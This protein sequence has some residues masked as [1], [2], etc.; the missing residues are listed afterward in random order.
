MN[1]ADSATYQIPLRLLPPHVVTHGVGILSEVH[2]Y[3]HRLLNVPHM[4]RSTRGRGVKV[5][6]LDTGVPSHNDLRIASGYSFVRKYDFDMN[7]HATHVAG[8]I[9]AIADNG[10][11][12]AGIA[13]DCSLLCCAV[14]DRTGFGTIDQIIAGIHWAMDQ[15]AQIINMSLGMPAGIP[16][17]AKLERACNEATAAGIT[18]FCATGNAGGAVGQPATYDSVISVAAVDDGAQHADFSNHGRQVDFAAGGVRVYST[19]LNNGYARLSGT[20]MATPALSGLAALIQADHYSGKGKFLTR[21]ELYAKLRK[22]AHD[23][24][25]E[26]FDELTG[27]GIP[28]FYSQD[29]DPQAPTAPDAPPTA[30]E[31]VTGPVDLSPK[32]GDIPMPPRSGAPEATAPIPPPGNGDNAACPS[33]MAALAHA[34]GVFTSALAAGESPQ[35]ALA[36]AF[37]AAG[38]M[39]HRVQATGIARAAAVD[40]AALAGTP[41]TPRLPR[42][43]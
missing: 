11:G 26:G 14:L 40:T 30:P 5:A 41:V 4:W 23:V 34:Q 19:Y 2:D 6:V 15:G 32:P 27:N 7:G 43:A 22:I 31:V 33:L 28:V 20:S 39:V 29:T 10:M 35:A 25:R 21:D 36:S 16:H 3:N 12:V 24:G 17:L 13:P 37:G 8:I 42:R 38:V 1:T 9:G 18:L